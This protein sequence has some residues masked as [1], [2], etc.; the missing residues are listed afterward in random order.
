MVFDCSVSLSLSVSQSFSISLLL[1]LC[2]VWLYSD[3]E[4]WLGIEYGW[5][6]GQWS[7]RGF[8]RTAVTSSANTSNLREGMDGWID[9]WRREGGSEGG[10]EGGGREGAPFI[11]E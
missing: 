9:G 1:S 10:R 5:K 3:K 11:I 7:G 4:V 2:L 8:R 6:G